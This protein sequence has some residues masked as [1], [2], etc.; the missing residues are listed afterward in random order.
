MLLRKEEREKAKA[1]LEAETR[2]RLEA[3]ELCRAG[4]VCGAT[5][6]P[7]AGLHLCPTCG[8]LK[9]S[10]CRKKACASARTPLLLTMQ[11]AALPPPLPAAE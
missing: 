4:C 7:S 3:F 6:C 2:A 11:P 8:D 1:Q 5:P 10:V 9:P